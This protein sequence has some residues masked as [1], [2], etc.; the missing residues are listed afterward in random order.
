MLYRWGYW[1]MQ[2]N[3]ISLL[4]GGSLILSSCGS[5]GSD[6]L[7]SGFPVSNNITTNVSGV[8][9]TPVRIGAPYTVGSK[10][11]TPADVPAYDEVGYASWYGSNFNGKNTANGEVFSATAF[12]AAHK[13]LPLPT[14]VEVTALDTGRTI[15]VRINDRGPFANDRLIDLSEAAAKQLGIIEQGVAGVRV[16]KVNPPEQERAI[17]RNGGPAATRTDTPESLTRIL[18][19]RLA[20]LPRPK[21]PD[22]TVSRS[23]VNTPSSNNNGRFVVEGSRNK[24]QPTTRNGRFVVE[25]PGTPRQNAPVAKAGGFVVQLSS[26]S[27]R[28]RADALARKVGA[29]V[30]PS[31][32]GN[33]F[34]VRY[35]P[36]ATEAQ[37]QEGLAN[38]QK[39]GYPQS[40][41]FRE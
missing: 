22:Q 26:F 18:Q 9:D 33:L 23:S 35:G 11:Y 41:I 8:S 36:Y 32:D 15:L 6:E 31:S 10:T 3:K 4:L 20:A 21:A 14:Y 29:T 30:V 39:R 38:A 34:R 16:R 5:L 40:R 17:L 27:S 24:P 25:G 37:A 28:A 7:E 19:K 13:T 1:Q 2:L 12:T